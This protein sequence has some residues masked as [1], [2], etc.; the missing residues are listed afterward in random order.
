VVVDTSAMLA[1]LLGEP[2]RR[3]FLEALE[4]ADIRRISAATFVEVSM[5]IES[6]HG[7]E[8]LR[9]LDLFLKTGNFEITALDSEQAYLARQAFSRF[10]KGRH[11]ANLNF[12]DCFSYALA[13]AVGE[14]LLCKGDDFVHTDLGTA[15]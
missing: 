6:R 12:G 3:A 14:A 1:I 7:G 11:R 5:V 2:E 13:K 10:G 9:D 4:Q 8:G 15:P